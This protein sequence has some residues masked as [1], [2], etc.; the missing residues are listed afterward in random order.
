MVLYNRDRERAPKQNDMKEVIKMKKE[1]M[2]L[3][4]AYIK[5]YNII[6]ADIEIDKSIGCDV[7]Y[8]TGKIHA[9]I[10]VIHDLAKLLNITVNMDL[11]G[12]IAE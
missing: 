9:L 7:R 3:L 11:K 12:T 10:D 2:K 6:N 5:K 8:D 4:K 1:M